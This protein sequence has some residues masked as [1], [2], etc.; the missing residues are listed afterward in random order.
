MQIIISFVNNNFQAA[1][2]KAIKD[3][4]NER[5]AR[6][7]VQQQQAD[8]A[9]AQVNNSQTVSALAYLQYKVTIY[10][11]FEEGQQ[12]DMLIFVYL[13]LNNRPRNKLICSFL[14]IYC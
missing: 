13:L 14:F 11:T 2:D 9:K 12:I 7:Q 5:H 8:S 1:Y 4:Y 10:R 6:E 3:A